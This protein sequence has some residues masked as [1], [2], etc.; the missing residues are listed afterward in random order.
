MI[1]VIL[2]SSIKLKHGM[3]V[4]IG[5]PVGSFYMQDN[6]PSLLI[7]GGGITPFRSILKQLEAEGN[8]DGKEKICSIWMAKSLISSRM[9]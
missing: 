2:K 7:A 8:H 6:S 9:S 4:K 3:K 5:G 1:P